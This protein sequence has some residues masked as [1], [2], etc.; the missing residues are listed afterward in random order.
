MLHQIHI[1]KHAVW[2]IAFVASAAVQPSS[3]H[4]KT[5]ASEPRYY[6]QREPG[7]SKLIECDV[8]VYGGTPAGVT[9]AIQAAREGKA[10]VLFS[11]NRHVGGM[12]SGG[13][14]ATDLGRKDS[15]GGLALEFYNRIG[16]ARDYRPSAAETLFRKMLDEAGVK[17]LLKRALQSVE[18][19]QNRLVS[20]TMETGETV[21][22]AMFIDSTYEGDLL[23][24]ASVSYRVGREPASAYDESLGGQW[25]TVSWKNVYQFCR[26][27]LSPFVIPDDPASGLLPEIASE[28]AG[29]RG[30]GDFKVQAYNFRIQLS[31]GDDRIAFPKPRGY[32]AERYALLAHFL[33]FDERVEWRLDYTTAALTDGPVQMRRGDSNNAGSFSS[34]YVGGN[35]RWPDG[36]YLPGSF[37]K[38]SPPRRGLP[39]PPRELYELRERIFQDHVNYQQGLMYFL[40][41]DPRVPDELRTRVRAWGLDPQEF[42]E[43]GFWPHQLY[44]REG[45]R[46][47]SDYV[48][49]QADCESRRVVTD[50][51]GLASYPMDSHFCQRVVI[52]E[53]GVQTVRKEGGFG[54]GFAKPYPVSYRAIVPR[55]SECDNLLVPVCLSSSHVAYGS[56]RMEPVFMI[57]GQSA[58]TAAAMAIT[59]KIAVQKVDYPALRA[60][61]AR[62]A[63]RL[64]WDQ[65]PVHKPAKMLT[66][67][68]TDDKDAQTA[69]AWTAGTLSPVFGPA[70]LHDG[71]TGKGE[72]TATFKISV[73]QP[74]TYEVNL[75]YVAS[76]NRSTTTPVTVSVGD[77]AKEL[78]VNQRKAT[79]VG[80]SLGKF[81]VNDCLM[82]TVS[83]RNTDGFVVVDGVQLLLQPQ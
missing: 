4:N 16:K 61:L 28:T 55:E 1:P 53:N 6:E 80:S 15:I 39:M 75:L 67:L 76:S 29:K 71:N 11:F 20:A 33:N 9:A 21:R 69:G 31:R 56:I 62:D 66:G 36:T 10:T 12:T 30:D 74:G 79:A 44:V 14:T 35:Y 48:V 65:T 22:A 58:G 45:R 63:Q 52:E 40:A 34:D 43:T 60:K 77:E 38:T 19:Q 54:H 50:S 73:P 57:L 83:N 24:A 82:V 32:D 7:Q 64:T 68:V 27:P 49:T 25:Q 46:M 59:E 42:K 8:A 81:R 3:F 70:Y 78:T 47:V 51:V 5:S 26:L 13:L 41:N 2:L 18:M 17:V 23:A 72:K 37:A